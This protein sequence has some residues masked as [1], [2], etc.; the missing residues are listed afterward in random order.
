VTSQRPAA[1]SS[2]VQVL[3]DLRWSQGQPAGIGRYILGLAVALNDHLR[4]RGLVKAGSHPP[5]PFEVTQ[6]RDRPNFSFDVL[7]SLLARRTGLPL[8]TL[9]RLPVLL[10]RKQ[11]MPIVGDLT[12]LILPHT[13]P[14]VRGLLERVTYPVA[15][16]A[17]TI[18]TLSQTSRH[19]LVQRLGILD[20]RV[21]VVRPGRSPSSNPVPPPHA[22]RGL[23]DMGVRG[24]YVLAIGTLEPRKNL[25]VLVEAFATRLHGQPLQ[26]VIAGG[27]GWKYQRLLDQLAPLER[28]GTV[29]RLGYV[30]EAEKALLLRQAMCLAYP[31]LY[32]G[33]GLPILEAMVQ[34][35]PVVV[36]NAPACLEVIGS[37]G[38]VLDPNDG[39]G[40]AD[41]ITR[42]WRDPQLRLRLGRSGQER[43]WQFS[44]PQSI[45]PLVERL[46][47]T[48]M[49]AAA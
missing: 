2:Q 5:V 48:E 49:V 23:Q 32:E 11:A 21:C 46:T 44:W 18:I 38:M 47:G 30:S 40:W 4:V 36:S 29:V 35:I 22:G 39:A 19:D 33:F 42:L 15:A 28:A 7:E 13:H 41:A 27:L 26:L 31:S 45:R 37:A 43:S 17:T 20:E 25:G 6:L 9:S 8:I 34:G 12:P 16:K 3:V 1:R 10:A 24:D 14:A